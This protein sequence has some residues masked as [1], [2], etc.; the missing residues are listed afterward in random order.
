V[1]IGVLTFFR[2]EL[3][4]RSMGLLRGSHLESVATS[5]GSTTSER[6]GALGSLRR[7]DAQR[8]VAVA[9][10][11]LN[12]ENPD[13][14]LAAGTVVAQA[15]LSSGQQTLLGML[16]DPN[17][18]S[19]YRGMAADRLAAL[20]LPEALALIVQLAQ[21]EAIRAENGAVES[22]GVGFRWT[23]LRA[24]GRSHRPS[25]LPIALRL[26][27]A[28]G[29]QAPARPLGLFGRADALPVLREARPLQ[30]NA[31]RT[32]EVELAISRCGG[33]D[34]SQFI[35]ELLRRGSL[36]GALEGEVDLRTEDPGSGRLTEYV[37]RDLGTHS[38]DRQ[39]FDDVLA[40]QKPT[41]CSFCGAAW[42]SLARMGTGGREAQLVARVKD[43][44]KGRIGQAI[45]VLAYNGAASQAR[46]L[47][48]HGGLQ[49]EAEACITAHE[50]GQ[51]R[52]W[53]LPSA[54]VPF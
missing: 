29:M 33:E 46:E 16:R 2:G 38:S 52:E 48:R 41:L 24:L 39:F 10:R 5:L 18:R 14:R 4:L 23:L 28:T 40:I 20:R 44:G 37:L 7:V 15:G 49:R 12:D 43:L 30:T 3:G 34:G 27:R 8:A 9:E 32:I 45:Q 11:L 35:H 22:D 25:D 36:I 1:L 31:E 54:G 53:F 17:L 13:L 50:R 51:D 21:S 19:D 6:L 42:G 26:Y 47:A